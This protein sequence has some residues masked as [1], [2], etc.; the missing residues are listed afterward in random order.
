MT[1]KITVA[2]ITFIIIFFILDFSL[3]RIFPTKCTTVQPDK[4]LRHS[5]IPGKNCT[6]RNQEFD[7]VYQI[8]SLGLRDT[9]ISQEKPPNTIRLLFLGDSFTYGTGVNLERS[10]VKK[11][12]SNLNENFTSQN[13]QAINTGVS[14]YTTINEYL[15]LKTKGINL[16]PDIVLVALNMTDFVEQKSYLKN[17]SINEDGEVISIYQETKKYVPENFDIIL[18]ENSFIYNIFLKKQEDL[19]RLKGK[20]IAFVQG[21]PQPAYTKQSSDFT[22]GDPERDIFA[23][24]R[25]IDSQQFD[26]LFDPVAQ[27][28]LNIKKVL[29]SQKIPMVLIIIPNGHQVGPNQWIKGRA[30]RKLIDSN[31][32]DK[33]QDKLEEFA[34]QNDINFIDTTKPLRNFAQK[35]PNEKLYFDFDGHFSP[36]GHALVAEYI[37]NKLIENNLIRN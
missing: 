28:L 6:D 4:I 9:Q 26:I 8:N 2:L 21:Q 7:V 30:I 15:Y 16:S 37:S 31:Y 17:A 1:K 13:F 24:T 10:F 29:D 5:L 18:R 20:V 3:L 14:A 32:P 36:L 27:E 33:V 23:I 34:K 35:N 11:V 12:E 25:N 22:P 19:V